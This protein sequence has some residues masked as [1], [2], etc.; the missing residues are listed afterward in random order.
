MTKTLR[1]YFEYRGVT[2]F[3]KTEPGSALRWSARSTNGDPLAAD[4]VEG[5]KQLIRESER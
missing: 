2:V 3:R 5:I 1:T 4:T